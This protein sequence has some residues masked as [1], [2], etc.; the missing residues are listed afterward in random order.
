MIVMDY[1]VCSECGQ[2]LHF[3]AWRGLSLVMACQACGHV[4]IEAFP[5]A[6]LECDLIQASE[7]A[8]AGK[9]VN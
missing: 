9:A 6:D 1:N 3:H 4:S 8:M 2:R 7:R 5:Y